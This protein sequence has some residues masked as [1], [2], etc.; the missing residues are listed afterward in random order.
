M[1]FNVTY[2]IEIRVFISSFS[3]RNFLE[4]AMSSIK[5]GKLLVMLSLRKQRYPRRSIS[6]FFVIYCFSKV[7]NG[8]NKMFS[9]Q[10]MHRLFSHFQSIGRKHTVS[11][12]ASCLPLFVWKPQIMFPILLAIN[13][14]SMGLTIN[15][16]M[17]KKD[18]R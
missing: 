3:A 4:P 5:K 6:L 7:L 11:E 9:L 2:T 10:T 14:V 8:S 1:D 18:S 17:A 12:K 13:R 15:R 16:K